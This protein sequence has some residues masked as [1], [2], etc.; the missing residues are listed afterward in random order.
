DKARGVGFDWDNIGQVWEKVEE[1]KDEFLQEVKKWNAL[2]ESLPKEE[3]EA[4]LTAEDAGKKGATAEQEAFLQ[5]RRKTLGE[6][7]DVFFAL[8]NYARFL[9]LNPEDALEQTNRK[10]INRFSYMEEQTIQKGK[11]LH[12]MSLDEMNRY[13]EEAK[14]SDKI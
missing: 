10:F 7:G 2:R 13:W 12:D 5:Q 1:E 6:L 8:I 9:K 3:Q 14:K 4:A 11:S